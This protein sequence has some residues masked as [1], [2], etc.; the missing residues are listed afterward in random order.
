MVEIYVVLDSELLKYFNGDLNPF[1]FVSSIKQECHQYINDCL[2]NGEDAA[3]L[4]VR[5]VKLT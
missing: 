5:Q 2:Q 4:V 1:R 3:R